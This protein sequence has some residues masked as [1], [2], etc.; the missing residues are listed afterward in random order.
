[1]DVNTAIGIGTFIAAAAAS[2]AAIFTYF[3]ANAT[4]R[5]STG[6]ALLSCLDKYISIMKDRTRALSEKSNHSAEE[7]YRELFDLHWS[8]FHLWQ[9][10]VI[11]DQFMR[12]WLYIRKRNYDSDKIIVKSTEGVEKAITYKKMWDKLK[13][14]NYFEINDP[15][16]RFMDRAH[17]A[18]ITD[19]KKLKKETRK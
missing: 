4:K 6:A 18:A 15:F 19:I 12:S 17:G 7:F 14:E 9:H 13:A 5:A 16:V 10:G 3:A 2:A 1:M 11:P 8:E